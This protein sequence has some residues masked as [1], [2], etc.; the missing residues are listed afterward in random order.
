MAEKNSKL[1]RQIKAALKGLNLPNIVDNVRLHPALGGDPFTAAE[2]EAQDRSL[3]AD[4][5]RR[6]QERQ[7]QARNRKEEEIRHLAEEKKRTEDALKQ[8]NKW[9]DSPEGKHRI[10]RSKARE[11]YEKFLKK[12]G[13][14]DPRGSIEIIDHN[15]RFVSGEHH[16]VGAFPSN[17]R[18]QQGK[19]VDSRGNI[20]LESTELWNNLHPDTPE[21]EKIRIARAMERGEDPFPNYLLQDDRGISRPW[22]RQFKY[23]Q[24]HLIKPE[25]LDEVRRERNAFNRYIESVEA[26]MPPRKG[27]WGIPNY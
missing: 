4:N 14:K 18:R 6:E 7:Q 25:F 11:D 27:A 10:A 8:F 26:G 15:R 22:L 19:W 3:S 23:E 1:D 13:G 5:L 2:L 17:Y 16:G 12:H 9:S 24:E 21:S 20:P